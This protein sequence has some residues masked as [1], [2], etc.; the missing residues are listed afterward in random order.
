DLKLRMELG[1]PEHARLAGP[2]PAEV[3]I[4][5][6]DVDQDAV[7]GGGWAV[8]ILQAGRLVEKPRRQAEQAKPRRGSRSA[9]GYAPLRRFAQLKQALGRQVARRGQVPRRG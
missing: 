3:G 2:P 6:A 1:I 7:V 9:I 4:V 5:A 8:T